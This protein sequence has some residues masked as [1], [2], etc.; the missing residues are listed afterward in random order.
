MVPKWHTVEF[1]SSICCSTAT[2]SLRIWT[3]WPS[4]VCS[5]SKLWALGQRD[6]C[7]AQRWRSSHSGQPSSRPC[8]SGHM[9]GRNKTWFKK[10]KMGRSDWVGREEEEKG[11]T[12]SFYVSQHY[13]NTRQS[14]GAMGRSANWAMTA[15]L[16]S[17]SWKILFSQPLGQ[18]NQTL[19]HHHS[20]L[21]RTFVLS[22]PA[23]HHLSPWLPPPSLT[24]PGQFSIP[25]LFSGWGLFYLL[26]PTLVPLKPWSNWQDTYKI[27]II[28]P[29][30]R[31]Q[32]LE[33]NHL[34]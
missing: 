34:L 19:Q 16:F 5:S 4:S 13:K 12:A 33:S 25:L 9:K 14:L 18:W 11:D 20:G 2:V 21:E 23:P 27:I 8:T 3:A 26:T 31:N 7:L 1:S 29:S 30:I 17:N 6:T 24:H 22:L 28:I 32:H 15:V 10:K